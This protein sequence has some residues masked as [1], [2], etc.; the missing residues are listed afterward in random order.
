M[1]GKIDYFYYC[2]IF[3]CGNL[4]YCICIC[5]YYWDICWMVDVKIDMLLKGGI[6]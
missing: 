3:I 6:F 2:I 4:F 5:N 1:F